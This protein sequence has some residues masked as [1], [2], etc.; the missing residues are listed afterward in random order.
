MKKTTQTGNDHS[1]RQGK[2]MR[3]S[4]TL[5]GSLFAV[6]FLPVWVPDTVLAQAPSRVL[7]EGFVTH[8]DNSVVNGA[9]DLI[10][11]LYNVETGGTA[12]YQETQTVDVRFGN[13]STEIGMVTPLDLSLF[14]D[15]TDLYVGVT[16]EEEPESSP[17]LRLAAR[18]YAASAAYAEDALALQGQDPADLM[19]GATPPASNVTYDNSGTGLPATTSQEAIDALVARIQALESETAQLRQELQPQIDT[20]AAAI[21]TNTGDILYLGSVA[22]DHETRIALM[23]GQV[24]D[25]RLT[26][27][28]GKTAS[29]FVSTVDGQP[30]VVF[31]GVN[32]IIQNGTGSTSTTDG[33]GNLVIGYNALRGNETDARAGSHNLVLGDKNNHTSTAYGSLLSGFLNDVQNAYTATI[34]GYQNAASGKYAS[35]TGGAMNKASGV[36]A[37]VSGGLYNEASAHCASVAGG[38]LNAANGNWTSVAGGYNNAAS[39]AYSSVAGG[40]YNEASAVYAS[41]A[42]GYSNTASGYSA[43]V[44]GGLYNEA[45]AHYASVAGGR[46]NAANGNWTSVAGGYN[47]AASGAYS[48][49]A[50]GYNNAASGNYASMAGGRTNEASGSFSA[51][52]GG[53]NRGVTGTYDWRAGGYFQDQ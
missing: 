17:R 8:S 48:S 28:E 24:L 41:V 3:Y 49:V 23:E 36:Y 44:A 11:S 20:N 46:L 39:G 34:A 7:Y 25:A 19:T 13:V 1:T 5:P 42:G 21:A 14:R 16:V 47:N 6:L 30:A 43:S 52:S 18:P 50:G 2:P 15:N 37:S 26:A 29:M 40:I 4:H 51:V 53:L 31:T 33:T 27:I 9:T 35:V 12:L 10:F 45:S 22:Q 32:V 38:R